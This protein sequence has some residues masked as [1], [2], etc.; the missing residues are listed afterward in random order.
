MKRKKLPTFDEMILNSFEAV[1]RKKQQEEEESRLRKE[2]YYP[3]EASYRSSSHQCFF[4]LLH[5]VKEAIFMALLIGWLPFVHKQL[6][7]SSQ[8]NDACFLPENLMYSK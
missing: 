5:L 1:N 7:R 2:T 3:K 8:V 6:F 4:M